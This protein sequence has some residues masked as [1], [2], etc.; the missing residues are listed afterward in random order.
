[1]CCPCSTFVIPLP[2]FLALYLQL[3]RIL[4]ALL[5]VLVS[6]SQRKI[7]DDGAALSYA[8]S[9]LSRPKK[10]RKRA[11]SLVSCSQEKRMTWVEIDNRL[12]FELE[13]AG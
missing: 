8:K 13:P 10:K 2:T 9:C 7:R 5:P 3:L 6:G 1:M 4:R 12:V 11:A